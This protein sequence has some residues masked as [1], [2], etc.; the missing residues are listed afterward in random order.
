MLRLTQDWETI[1]T[2]LTDIGDETIVHKRP[3]RC[4][5]TRE[6]LLSLFTSKLEVQSSPDEPRNLSL[7]AESR[8]FTHQETRDF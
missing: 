6:T 1:T 4:P 8:R 3:M 2:L 7:R 5:V